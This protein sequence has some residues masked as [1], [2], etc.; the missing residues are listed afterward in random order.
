MTL[1]SFFDVAVRLLIFACVRIFEIQC[2]HFDKHWTES[3]KISDVL[4]KAQ[5]SYI[6]TQDC[7]KL[8]NAH[9][10]FFKAVNI[11]ILLQKWNSNWKIITRR[12]KPVILNLNTSLKLSVE[13]NLVVESAIFKPQKDFCLKIIT[14]FVGR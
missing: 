10:I 11:L 2:K 3:S 4:L 6:M 9:L 14:C 1:A 8:L 7:I 12:D 5:S 13:D